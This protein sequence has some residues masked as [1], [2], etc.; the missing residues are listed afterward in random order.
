VS[1]VDHSPLSNT[2]VTNAWVYNNASMACNWTILP[3][4]SLQRPIDHYS[5]GQKMHFL[6][7]E[8][9]YDIHRIVH[10]DILL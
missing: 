10:R 7:I 8:L 1:E 5:V 9:Q 3:P 4:A 6:V 2:E